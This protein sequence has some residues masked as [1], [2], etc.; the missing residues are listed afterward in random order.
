MSALDDARRAVTL[1]D[2]AQQS[3][4]AVATVNEVRCLRDA[5]WALIAYVEHEHEERKTLEDQLLKLV[6]FCAELEHR[7]WKEHR[8]WKQE[9]DD[10][11]SKVNWHVTALENGLARV[12]EWMKDR[13]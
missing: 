7:V 4:S 5:L 6:D 8:G 10:Q 13:S 11:F 12:D 3:I 2:Q 1:S 9:M